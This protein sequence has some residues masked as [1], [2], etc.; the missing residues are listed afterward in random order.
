MHAIALRSL[1]HNVRVFEKAGDRHESHMAGVCLAADALAF[2]R[3]HDEYGLDARPFHLVSNCLQILDR[4]GDVDFFVKAPRAI[5]S[6]DAMYWHLRHAFE[7]CPSEFYLDEVQS[8]NREG[9]DKGVYGGL[10][11]GRGSEVTRRNIGRRA[12]G[13]DSEG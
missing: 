6:W 2:L 11:H 5:T 12:Y 8:A 10:S 13:G 1:G 3:A 4:A 9:E 7:G